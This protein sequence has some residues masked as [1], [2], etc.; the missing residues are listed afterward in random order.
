MVLPGGCLQRP[1]AGVVRRGIDVPLLAVSADDPP[2]LTANHRH[3]SF[4]QPKVMCVVPRVAELMY[5]GRGKVADRITKPPVGPVTRFR[6]DVD[7]PLRPQLV[8]CRS[9][10][11]RFVSEH[12]SDRPG[13]QRKVAFQNGPGPVCSLA[14]ESHGD[15]GRLG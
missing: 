6:V 11:V 7:L 4:R 15:R 2:V 14:E 1:T 8:V 12:N 10:P 13:R 3:E 9:L 5:K